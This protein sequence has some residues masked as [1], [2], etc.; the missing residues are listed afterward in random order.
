MKW[1]TN[2]INSLYSSS[3]TS[4]LAS[5]TLPPMNI[6]ELSPVVPI[7]CKG[8]TKPCAHPPLP[9]NLGIDQSK[10]LHNTI[11]PYAIHILIMTGKSNWPAHIE[12]EGLAHAFIRAIRKR[13]GTDQRPFENRYHPA[14]AADDSQRVIVTNCSL[15]SV[16]STRGTDIL[17]LPDNIIISNITPKRVDTLL[18][19]IFGKPCYHAFSTYSFP[20][21][22]LILVCGHGNKD[23]RCGTI[24]P[25][26]LESL[27]QA[28]HQAG[29]ESTK[30]ALVS[31]LGGHAFAGNL[32]VYT[33]HGRRAIWYGRVTPCYCKDIVE[34]TLDDNK[35][36][37][38]L[39]RGIFEV[40]SKPKICQATLEW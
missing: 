19:Y 40:K 13:K 22:S 25:I 38:D 30:V 20:Y 14:F 28:S 23:R 29:E 24:G 16:H 11:P 34:N 21:S 36:I 26:L 35:V 39:V 12:D 6:Q 1:L 10:P 2:C 37:E 17:L 27:E 33:Y 31:H 3:C 4:E 7:D 9:P 32:V 18:D 5:T 8:C 15:P